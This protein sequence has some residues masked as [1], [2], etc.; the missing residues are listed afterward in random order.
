MGVCIQWTGPLD[1]TSRLDY[2]TGK[3]RPINAEM[4]KVLLAIIVIPCKFH[5]Q[6][7]IA[8]RISCLTKCVYSS[9]AGRSAFII[10]VAMRQLCVSSLARG[11]TLDGCAGELKQHDGKPFCS[12]WSHS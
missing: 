2:W 1:W 6:T 10:V 4:G 3:P 9:P 8:G 5:H 12:I 7:T 11:R